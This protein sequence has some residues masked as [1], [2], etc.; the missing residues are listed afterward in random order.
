MM[1]GHS[2]S[3]IEPSARVGSPSSAT[4]GHALGVAVGRRAHDADDD[5]GACCCPGGRST[6]TSGRRRRGRARRTCRPRAVS[7]G[8][9]LVRVHGAAAPRAQHLLGVVV[10]RLQ[11]PVGGSVTRRDARAR[12]VADTRQRR[13]AARRPA[14]RSAR[15]RSPPARGP[16]PS[17]SG[18]QR[19]VTASELV[20]RQVDRR[21]DVEHTRFPCSRRLGG[22]S[23]WHAADAVEAGDE[24]VLELGQRDDPAGRVAHRGEVAHLGQGDEPLVGRVVACDAVEQVQSSAAGR[25]VMSKLASRHSWRRAGDHRVQAAETRSSSKPP[26]GAGG[27]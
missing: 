19:R 6:G 25:R 22:R 1:R 13:R 10:E 9:Q 11:R 14:A 2:G 12:L 21:P 18:R 27:T 20:E 26:V 8:H 7:S 4:R 24:H 5:A 15:L 16:R 17:V 23:A 3:A